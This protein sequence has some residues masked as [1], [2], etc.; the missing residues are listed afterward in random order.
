MSNPC[1]SL[2]PLKTFPVAAAPPLLRCIPENLNLVRRTTSCPQCMEK[3]EQELAK[4]VSEFE[5]TPSDAN[6]DSARPTLPQWLQNAKQSNGDKG[7]S[8]SQVCFSI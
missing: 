5:N 8:L 7:T 6:S 1:E 2:S 4:L 3:Y